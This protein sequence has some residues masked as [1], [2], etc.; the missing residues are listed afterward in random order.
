MIEEPD[1]VHFIHLFKFNS[2]FYG[3]PMKIFENVIGQIH[4]SM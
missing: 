2:V 3:Q 4:L 1:I